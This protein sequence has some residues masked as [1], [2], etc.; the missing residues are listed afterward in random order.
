MGIPFVFLQF[1][2]KYNLLGTSFMSS[3]FYY[4][5]GTVIG[6]AAFCF[7]Y[8][9]TIIFLLQKPDWFKTL[10][11]LGDVGRIAL[12]NYLLQ[13]IIATTVFY[14]YGLGLFGRVGPA[15]GII[16]TFFIFIL[17]VYFSRYWMK[18][19]HFGPMEWLWRTLTYGKL[20]PFKRT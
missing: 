4:L 12:T 1:I 16:L 11:P 10:S 19:Y 9:T 3:Q 6:G 5:T 18:H 7:L 20:Q 2:G 14:G 15:L 8:I 13:S 17:Q